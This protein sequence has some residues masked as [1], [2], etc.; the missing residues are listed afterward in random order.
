[1]TTP[2]TKLLRASAPLPPQ[3]LHICNHPITQIACAQTKIGLSVQ[4][5]FVPTTAFSFISAFRCLL[6]SNDL[7]GGC[8]LQ[9]QSMHT[10]VKHHVKHKISC[11][12]MCS[13]LS[14][15]FCSFSFSSAVCHSFSIYCPNTSAPTKHYLVDFFSFLFFPRSVFHI[16]NQMCP[17]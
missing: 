3:H 2:N 6:S 13:E 14:K 7:H 15:P 8:L 12:F 5:E 4:S 17:S 10:R 9:F 1:M 16:D 11:I